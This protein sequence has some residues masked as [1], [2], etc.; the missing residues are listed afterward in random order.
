[1][2][3][4]IVACNEDLVLVK[5]QWLCPNHDFREVVSEVWKMVDKVCFECRNKRAFGKLSFKDSENKLCEYHSKSVKDDW[6]WLV[7]GG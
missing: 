6:L 5:G 3:C 4:N 1:M 7:L 2:K